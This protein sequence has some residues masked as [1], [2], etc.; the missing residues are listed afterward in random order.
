MT[1]RPN[2][3]VNLDPRSR[4]VSSACTD[5]WCRLGEQSAVH[6]PLHHHFSRSGF[7][8]LLLHE[9]GA[10]SCRDGHILVEA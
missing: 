4:L 5:Y 1:N 2:K 7:F 6:Q 10:H 9:I 3:Q 8:K